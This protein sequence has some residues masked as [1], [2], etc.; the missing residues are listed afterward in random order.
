M[1]KDKLKI[2]LTEVGVVL[3]GAF[4]LCFWAL[5]NHYP[6]YFN[7]D[8]A[9]YL[10]HAFQ[11]YV[12]PDRPIMYGLFMYFVSLQQTLWLVIVLQAIIVSYLLYLYFKLFSKA[13]YYK[14][15]FLVFIVLITFCTG[16]SFDVS[17][18]LADVFTSVSI[19]C[20]G[21]LLFIKRL[22][23]M[24]RVSVSVLLVLASAMHN[25]HFYIC[26][27]LLIMIVLGYVFNNIRFKYKVITVKTTQLLLALALILAGN[28]L[29]ASVHYG[30]GAGF[31]S[32][33][34][35]EIF[36]FGNL[37]EMGIVNPYLEENCDKKDYQ[38]CA[39]RDTLPNCFLWAPNSP[40]RKMGGWEGSKDEFSAIIKDIFTTPKYLKKFVYKSSVYVAKQ[41]CHFDT[42]E[43]GK[44]TQRS[45]SAFV[46][47]FSN[48]YDQ[49][50]DAKQQ[51]GELNF[52]TIN[53]AQTILFG[54]CLLFYIW[55]FFENKL[56]PELWLFSVFILLAVLINAAI[57]SVFSGVYF[58]YQ[59]RVVWLLLLPV[60]LFFQHSLFA[61]NDE[62][63]SV[64][65][66][67]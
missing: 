41:M 46:S 36:L 38:I 22:S 31:K 7:S 50:S 1:N 55:A 49:F 48:E 66:K 5:Y 17:W 44:P 57:C 64:E 60:F 58:R 52:S 15:Y 42:G 2:Y 39:Y 33:R 45:E 26:L 27:G 40:I 13:M 18:L 19:L 56:T 20:L 14:K 8:T 12:G 61:V 11:G 35:G 37:V 59:A 23:I 51:K 25:S 67:S 21:L 16:A 34:G 32:S 63:K 6:L 3:F 28:L 62:M 10:D 29:T 53:Y 30:Y 4:I 54:F 43:A 9:M 65:S 24:H 47:Y